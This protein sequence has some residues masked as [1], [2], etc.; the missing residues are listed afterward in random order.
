MRFGRISQHWKIVERICPWPGLLCKYIALISGGVESRCCGRREQR[1]WRRSSLASSWQIRVA[2]GA[3]VS[4][5]AHS[6]A[7]AGLHGDAGTATAGSTCCS[8]PTTSS[9]WSCRSSRYPRPSS[10]SGGSGRLISGQP[11]TLS[12]CCR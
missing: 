11:I 10:R 9:R 8:Y 5:R 3:R 7:T 12:C 6:N 1:W 4:G 2:G